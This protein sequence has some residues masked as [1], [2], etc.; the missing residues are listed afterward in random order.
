MYA[1]GNVGFIGRKN[2][3]EQT[4]NYAN[5]NAVLTC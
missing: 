1:N 5:K 2:C 3:L 4:A